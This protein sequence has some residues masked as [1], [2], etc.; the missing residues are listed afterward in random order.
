MRGTQ[1]FNIG[2]N[3]HMVNNNIRSKLAEKKV[4]MRRKCYRCAALTDEPSH[5]TTMEVINCKILLIKEY[6][7]LAKMFCKK[8][9]KNNLNF[10]V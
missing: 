5:I 8:S 9:G 6:Y 7:A 2:K 10:V 3:G 4:E 1:P